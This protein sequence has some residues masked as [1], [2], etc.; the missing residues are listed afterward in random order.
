MQNRRLRSQS[1]LIT[2]WSVIVLGLTAGVGDI[3]EAGNRFSLIEFE[4]SSKTQRGRLLARDSSAALFEDE[5]ARLH[6]VRLS[7]IKRVEKVGPFYHWGS[8]TMRAELAGE[9][10]A[11]A[12][13]QGANPFLV[14][15]P[16]DRVKDYAR[17]LGEVYGSFRR[18]LLTRGFDVAEP[19]SV[20]VVVVFPNREMFEA[21]AQK[22]KTKISRDLVG[23][24]LPTSN[25]IA[26][27]AGGAGRSARSSTGMA[28]ENTLVH[29]ATHQLAFNMGLHDRVGQNPQWVVEGFATVFEAPG[30]RSQ[31]G[32]RTVLDRANHDRLRWFRESIDR[33]PSENALA[34]FVSSDQA[35]QRS[36][37][38][39]YA[40]AWALSFYLLETRP[41]A[42]ARYLKRVASRDSLGGYSAAERLSDFEA[43][44]GK[45]LDMLDADF[46]RFYKKLR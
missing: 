42:Y 26:L 21:Y 35:F 38:D 16:P 31:S 11:E 14:V 40:E 34:K 13:Y 33:R 27:Y 39:A 25:R 19:T 24:Y 6:Y 41:V 12:G 3:A 7:D 5:A 30:V 1:R 36:A 29:E 46:V 37:L 18:F 44:F 45:N 28:I 22:E 4:T 8:R 23:Y 15:G 10:G 9:F 2:C 20:L 17:V 43:E 32:S